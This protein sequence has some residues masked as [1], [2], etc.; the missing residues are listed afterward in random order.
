[1]LAASLFPKLEQRWLRMLLLLGG[2]IERNPGPRPSAANKRIPRGELDM[3]VGLARATSKRMTNCVR[4]FDD[5]NEWLQS[6]A[7]CSVEDVCWDTMA[8]PLA[9]QA[10]GMHLYQQGFPKYLVVYTIAGLQDSY[11]HLKPFTA[12]AWA[13]DRKWQAAEPGVCRPVISAPVL[14]AV[15]SLCILWGWFRF[16][17]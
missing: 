14:R 11:P 17:G 10:Y 7:S 13:I 1:M 15:A 2:D 16:L 9:V 12:P 5:I 4:L 6:E 3:S 8:A